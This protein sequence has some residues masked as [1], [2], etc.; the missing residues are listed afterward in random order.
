MRRPE[1]MRLYSR[2]EY[3]NRIYVTANC[4]SALNCGSQQE[5]AATTER[6]QY[7]LTNL[8]V[9][10]NQRVGNRRVKLRGE[11]EEVMR[12]LWRLY[13]IEVEALVT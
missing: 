2:D 9:R 7:G 11:S 3:S 10:P 4:I 5:R 6:V 1:S 12:E 8:C 13:V